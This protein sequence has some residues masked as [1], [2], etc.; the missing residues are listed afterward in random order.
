[1]THYFRLEQVAEGAWAALAHPG[2]GALGNAGFV[3]LGDQTIIFDTFLTPAA[4][5]ELRAEAERLTGRRASFVVN[6]HFHRDHVNGN[7]VFAGLPIIATAK[8][9][10]IM[11]G[12]AGQSEE[13]HAG[14]TG[15][16]R[17]TQEKL[18]AETD[19]ARRR[20]MEYNLGNNRAFLAAL[21]SLNLTLPNVTFTD[22]LVLHG[23]RRNAEVITYGGGHS[24]GDAFLWLPD[25]GVAF[26]GDLVLVRNH[27]WMGHGHPEAWMPMLDRIAEL[28]IVRLVPGHGEVGGTDAIGTARQYLADIMTLVE[29]LVAAGARPADAVMPEAYRDW[30]S[31]AVFEWNTGTFFER[32]MAR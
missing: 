1:M 22:R 2:T 15:S 6:S 26:M 10:E 12:T 16:I 4:A 7:Q 27:L 3:D 13:L 23:S 24:D 29:E 20:V 21:P 17:T 32:L 31:A 30:G 19:P 28:P 18:A 9:R 11:F 8:T 5:Q 14:L 25:E